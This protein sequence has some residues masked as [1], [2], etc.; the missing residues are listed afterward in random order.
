ML[1]VAGPPFLPKWDPPDHSTP[2][3]G[4]YVSTVAHSV[5]ST[6]AAKTEHNEQRQRRPNRKIDRRKTH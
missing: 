1:N 6:A 4:G 5:P 3:R 2:E